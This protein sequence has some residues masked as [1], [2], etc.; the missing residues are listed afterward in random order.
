MSELVK[1]LQLLLAD[2][3]NSRDEVMCAQIDE[4]LRCITSVFDDDG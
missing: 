3:T 1:Y 4:V 2:A